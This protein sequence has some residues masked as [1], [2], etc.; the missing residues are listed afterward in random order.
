[1]FSLSKRDNFFNLNSETFQSL[2]GDMVIPNVGT[3]LTHKRE[4]DKELELWIDMPGVKKDAVKL[5]IERGTLTVSADRYDVK[6]S[7][8]RTLTINTKYNEDEAEAKL[9]NGVLYIRVPVRANS[10]KPSK[11]IEIK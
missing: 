1:M 4:T 10:K 3:A 9:E 11:T 5:S 7:H 6:G 2:F 8:S